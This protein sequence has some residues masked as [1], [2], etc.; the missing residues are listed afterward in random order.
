M[1][2]FIKFQKLAEENIKE[3]SRVADYVKE[4]GLSTKSLNKI[5]KE[6]IHKTAKEFLDEIHLKQ[7]KRLLINSKDSVKE[8]AYQSGFEEPSNFY[9]FFKRHTQ[10][11][12]EQ[13]RNNTP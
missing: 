3:K 2:N 11:T 13:F 1:S 10:V 6:T 8:I 9:K 7:I 5:T 12:P 4:M